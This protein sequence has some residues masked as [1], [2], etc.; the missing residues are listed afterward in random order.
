MTTIWTLS[1]GLSVLRIPLALVFL[2]ESPL[3]RCLAIFFA[4]VTDVLDGYLARRYRQ[5]SQFG[6]VLDPLMDKFF[7]GFAFI[8]LLTE[9]RLNYAELAALV[10]RDIAV[11]LFGCYLFVSGHLAGYRF[12]AIWCGKITTSLQ[13]FV[14]M[15]LT[16]GYVVPSMI[17]GTFVALGVFALIELYLMGRPVKVM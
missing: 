14:L 17:Y 1:N 9:G 5:T 3:V 10:C 4:M 2:I 12:R 8:V 6:A 13:F 11:I 16:L 7:A 15:A